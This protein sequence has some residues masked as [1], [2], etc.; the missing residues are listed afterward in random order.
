M[1]GDLVER[2][3]RRVDPAT[4]PELPYVGLEHLGVGTLALS[5]HGVAADVRSGCLR[6][7]PGDIVFGR[8]RPYFRKL[9]VAPWAAVCTP[10]AWVLR[11]RPHVDPRFAFY[12]LA[13]PA[14]V[15]A[16]ARSAEGTRMPRASWSFAADWPVRLPP[17]A[18]QRWIG[19]ALALFD[20]RIAAHRA[21]LAPTAALL[22]GLHRRAVAG[23]R[24]GSLADVAAEVR[25]SVDPRGVDP[26]LPYVGLDHVPRREIALERWGRAGEVT[27][28]KAA[29]Q[30][31]DLLFGKLRP[32]F[33]KVVPAHV[34]GVAST[35]IV[36]VRPHEPAWRWVVYGHLFS[37]ALVA[38]AAAL[39]DGTR[40]PRTRWAD[41]CR[42]PVALPSEADRDALHA[43]LEPLMARV[44]AGV[45]ERHRLARLRDGLLTGSL[46][47]DA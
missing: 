38:H 18:E 16:C 41:L 37:D 29:F 11:A 5:G 8:L 24:V 33:H 3:R 25:E 28:T 26:E 6:V 35:D 23:G 17:L 43:Q 14:F 21:A 2:V 31:G 10:E 7:E 46:T 39:A 42:F 36:V 34:D 9:A 19:A 30:R 47:P 22:R 12:V 15:D 40:M 45:G 13:D 1:L 27:S 32:V 44:A 4:C 20:D